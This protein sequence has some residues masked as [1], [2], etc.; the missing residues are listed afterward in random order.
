MLTQTAAPLARVAAP[1]KAVGTHDQVSM[2]SPLVSRLPASGLS[3]G[4]FVR[5]VLSRHRHRLVSHEV[6]LARW[7]WSLG[8][9][10]GDDGHPLRPPLYL[11]FHPSIFHAPS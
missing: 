11:V 8:P 6:E 10:P 7:Q 4:L 9:V 5:A 3:D 1:T 2:Q